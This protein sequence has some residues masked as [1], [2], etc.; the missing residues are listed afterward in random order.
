MLVEMNNMD[1]GE[2]IQIYDN[3]VFEKVLTIDCG[4]LNKRKFSYIVSKKLDFDTPIMISHLH[5]DHMNYFVKYSKFC[6]K[7]YKKVYLPCITTHNN[8]TGFVEILSDAILDL[9]IG[10]KSEESFNKNFLNKIKQISSIVDY[11]NI[12]FLQRGDCRQLNSF[13]KMKVLWPCGQCH[14]NNN[15]IVQDVENKIIEKLGEFD[16]NVEIDN[17]EYEPILNAIKEITLINYTF[18]NKRNNEADNVAIKELFKDKK[19]KEYNHNLNVLRNYQNANGCIYCPIK[20]LTNIND[21]SIVCEISENN[22]CAL[23]TGDINWSKVGKQITSYSVILDSNRQYD[24]CKIP[25]HGT[26]KYIKSFPPLAKKYIVSNGNHKRY[27]IG[28]SI[29]NF[30]PLRCTNGG[31]HCERASLPV[32]CCSNH[33]CMKGKTIFIRL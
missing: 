17:V 8:G 25:H 22:K 1:F 16:I 10:K 28:N 13:I 26:E 30:M 21:L 31:K 3:W 19:W 11:E 6:D 18:Y 7:K 14:S 12:E 23:F 4:S 5:D 33:L 20:N 24:L 32:G 15:N 2:F 29:N 9:L 27:C